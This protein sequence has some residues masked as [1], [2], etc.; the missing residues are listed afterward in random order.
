M[1]AR[2]PYQALLLL[3]GSPCLLPLFFTGRAAQLPADLALRPRA[4]LSR[5]AKVLR[6]ADG[7]R[8]VPWARIPEGAREADELGLLIQ[9]PGALRGLR[10][11]LFRLQTFKFTCG[12]FTSGP[13]LRLLQQNFFS[14]YLQSFLFTCQPPELRLM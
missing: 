13:Q 10:C 7:I 12:F 2:A 5:L 1:F 4:M 14:R 8:V 3:L 11:C 9:V 6:R